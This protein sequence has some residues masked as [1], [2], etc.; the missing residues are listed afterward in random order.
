M[1]TSF[2]EMIDTLREAQHVVR[3][4]IECFEQDRGRDSEVLMQL[5]RLVRKLAGQADSLLVVMTDRD[6]ADTLVEV[7]EEIFDFFSGTEQKIENLLRAG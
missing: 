4:E 2:G 5:G 1:S 6:A 3:A 7:A